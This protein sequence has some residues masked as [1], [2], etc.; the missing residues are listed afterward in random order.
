VGLF[1]PSTHRKVFIDRQI[2]SDSYPTAVTLAAA[3]QKEYGKTIDPR[4]IAADIASLRQDY[5]APITYDYDRHGY[6]YTNPSYK[7]S[8]LSDD[9]NLT[10]PISNIVPESFPKTAFVPEWHQNLLSALITKVLPL[11]ENE[12]NAPQYVSLLAPDDK[13]ENIAHSLL[14]KALKT[15]KFLNVR[16]EFDTNC[17]RELAFLPLR[18]I[19]SLENHLVFGVERRY[20]EGQYAIL[21]YDKIEEV[22]FTGEQAAP[23]PFISVQ[24]TNMDDIEVVLSCDNADTLLVFSCKKERLLNR[25]LPEYTL[26]AKTELYTPNQRRDISALPDILD[27]DTGKIF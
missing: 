21:H 19:F 14:V 25:K 7:L 12:K 17:F 2:R 11:A 26:L 20:R 13:K 10:V 18:L 16:Y 23:V 6:F 4:T 24:T 9:G 1:K 15:S 22:D 3:Y 5:G 27:F 8:L